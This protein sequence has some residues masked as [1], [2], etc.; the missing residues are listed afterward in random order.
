MDAIFGG[1]RAQRYPGTNGFKVTAE[2]EKMMKDNNFN[3]KGQSLM[4]FV[5]RFGTDDVIQAFLKGFSGTQEQV[6]DGHK[7]IMRDA[8]VLQNTNEASD[9]PFAGYLF[10]GEKDPRERPTVHEVLEL[11][12]KCMKSTTD[13]NAIQPLIHLFDGSAQIKKRR[14]ISTNK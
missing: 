3:K 10:R 5:F 6:T 11:A 14:R 13:I 8:L 2:L 12:D 4:Y 7:K 9:F 1:K